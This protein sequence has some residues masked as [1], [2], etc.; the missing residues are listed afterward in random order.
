MKGMQSHDFVNPSGMIK[1]EVHLLQSEELYYVRVSNLKGMGD[2]LLNHIKKACLKSSRVMISIPIEEYDDF[3]LIHR[4]YSYG[5]HGFALRAT[6]NTRDLEHT[7]Y[8]GEGGDLTLVKKYKTILDNL[9]DDKEIIIEFQNVENEKSLGPT[10]AELYKT[11][12]SWC[13]VNL[14]GAPREESCLQMR[15]VFEYL[16][17]RSCHK[18]NVYFPFWNQYFRE[19]DIRTQNV[20]SGLELVH[21][22]I[23]NRCTHSCIF[24]G[25]YSPDAIQEQ[26]NKYSKISDELK[27]HMRLEINSDRCLEILNS[28]PWSVKYIQFGGFGDP[29]IHEYAVKFIAKARSR[30]FLV[31]VLSNMEYLEDQEIQELHQLGGKNPFDLHFVV[32]MS[33]GDSETYIKTRPKQTK[34]TFDKIVNNLKSFSELRKKNFNSG[35]HLTIMCVVNKLNCEKLLDVAKLALDVGAT[36]IW[37]KALE[38]H[39]PFMKSYLPEGEQLPKLA[40]S[41]AESVQFAEGHGIM[42]FQKDYCEQIINQYTME[43]S[44]V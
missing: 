23:T 38:P 16:K 8:S 3:E 25:L 21:L 10:I 11:G 15:N 41:I 33:G 44:N 40:K 13:V 29:L 24:C 14:E 31:E 12:L 36:R 9:S 18:L 26:K 17:I 4:F 30:G 32:N 2:E 37:F 42:V 22:D 1:S 27:E 19:W 5:V 28:L 20:F 43:K 7:G 34:T 35:V 39:A 6:L